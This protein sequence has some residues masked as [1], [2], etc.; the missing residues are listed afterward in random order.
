M[1]IT[2][3]GLCGSDEL[4]LILDLGQQP[5][6]ERFDDDQTYPLQLLKCRSCSLAQLSFIV[7]QEI[8]FPPGHPYASGNTRALV[9]HFRDL[10]ATVAR[11]LRAGDLVVDI[12]A[13]DGTFLSSF[14][15]V[16]RRL[17]VDPTDQVRKCGK[18][19]IIV[20]QGFFTAAMARE[21]LD[22]HGEA[23]LITAS[24]VLAHVPDPHDFMAGVADLLAPGGRFVTENHAL[25]SITD[26]LQWDTVYHEHLRY[27]S[28]QSLSKLLGMHGMQVMDA[29]RIPL[30]GG[31]FRTYATMR[32]DGL[33][34]Y[35][36]NSAA[37]LRLFLEAL[38]PVSIYGIG[39]ATRAVPLIH[40]ARIAPFLTCVCEVPSSDKIGCMM[41]GTNIPVVPEAKL[42]ADQPPYA[43]LF[44]W[45]LADRL[46]PALRAEGYTGKF[47]VPLPKARFA[48]A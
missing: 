43:L 20:R 15:P 8:L 5:I 29:E 31:S 12:G 9:D 2:E 26:G 44:P 41:P 39:A 18:H 33:A 27:Y 42:F 14:T 3:C 21:I 17:A 6:A 34:S 4:S 25:E 13:N 35:A 36:A 48:D 46:A 19:G 11:P 45:H 23:Q 22:E 10:A 7:D 28:V 24:N 1:L 38:G 40:Y 47:I 32:G 37:Q 30:H 16:V